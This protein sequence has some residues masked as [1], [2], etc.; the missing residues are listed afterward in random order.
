MGF[1]TDRKDIER[2]IYFWRVVGYMLG[3][4]DRYNLCDGDYDTVRQNCQLVF[5]QNLRPRLSKMDKEA[6]KMSEDIMVT[7]NQYVWFIRYKSIFRYL[8]E[9]TN[10]PTESFKLSSIETLLYLAFKWTLSTLLY[11]KFIAF[12]LNNLLRFAF[13]R[14]TISK[15]YVG[16]IVRTLESMEQ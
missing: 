12:I 16:R 15:A 14:L 10:L 5:E 4:E 9:I 11:N 2:L 3:I 7:A 1:S 13:Y 8:F 6:A